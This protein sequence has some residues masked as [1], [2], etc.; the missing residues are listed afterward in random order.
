[1]RHTLA[2]T[3][4]EQLDT[5]LGNGWRAQPLA[6][7]VS[8]GADSVALAWACALLAQAEGVPLHFFHVHHGLMA[9]A[10]QW[11]GQVDRLA[12]QLGATAHCA[13]VQVESASTAGLEAAARQ[14]RYRALC[15]L[16]HEQKVSAVLLAHH[17]D[18]QVETLLFRLFRGT[19]LSGM[20]GMPVRKTREG[21]TFLRPLLFTP[22]SQLLQLAQACAQACG[23]PLAEDPSNLDRA[24]A[25]GQLRQAVIPAIQ[26]HWPGYR[27]TLL[28]FSQHCIEAEAELSALTAQDYRHCQHP[29]H[30]HSLSARAL[31]EMTPWRAQRV[32]RHWLQQQSVRAPA[33]QRLRQWHQQL[34]QS[35]PDRHLELKHERWVI[36]RF[37]DQVCL[38]PQRSVPE[39]LSFRW[40]GEAM[41]AFPGFAGR[42]HFEVADQGMDAD[43][44]R[45]QALTLDVRRGGERLRLHAAGPART[46]KNLYQE[47]GVPPWERVHLPVLRSGAGV[48][49]AGGCGQAADLPQAAPGIRLRWEPAC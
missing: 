2:L 29:L 6:L 35:A 48:L 49:F 46:L 20:A 47:A 36:H 34:T 28:R 42:L 23:I 24:Y 9:D 7:A 11:A 27:Q 41:L 1:M 10:D 31:G 3:V 25:R 5:E 22:R 45:R 8:G 13:R 30:P 26:A 17:Q 33:E 19:G 18:D 15:Q 39:T 40:R 21:V 12:R 44:L 43:W 32:L 16:A 37:R 14:A 38:V 4:R